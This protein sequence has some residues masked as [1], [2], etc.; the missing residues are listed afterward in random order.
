MTNLLMLS[1]PLPHQQQDWRKSTCPPG[2]HLPC[3]T[4]STIYS[5]AG[6]WCIGCIN[7]TLCRGHS[8]R[9]V[10][11]KA[12]KHCYGSLLCAAMENTTMEA[13]T[14]DTTTTSHG[15]SGHSWSWKVL[16]GPITTTRADARSQRTRMCGTS[17]GWRVV[18]VNICALSKEGAVSVNF[19]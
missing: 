1:F 9:G 17:E 8:A 4:I 5:R 2:S 19:S 10:A 6:C 14:W 7:H 13:L 16:W 3:G 12:G 11:R 15:T 18:V